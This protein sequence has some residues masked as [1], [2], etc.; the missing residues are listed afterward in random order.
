[1]NGTSQT[2]LIRRF[3]TQALLTGKLPCG[4]FGNQ[5]QLGAFSEALY[6]TREFDRVLA[7]SE[8]LELLVVGGEPVYGLEARYG[9]LFELGSGYE[10]LAVGGRRMLVKGDPAALY[11]GVRTAVGFAKELDYLPFEV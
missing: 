3:A 7:E 9:R 2:T 6:A 8:D 11:R 1:M 10:R 5:R 4:I